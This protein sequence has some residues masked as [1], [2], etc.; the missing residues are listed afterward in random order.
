MALGSGPPAPAAQ[1]LRNAHRALTHTL[2]TVSFFLNIHELRARRPWA[3]TGHDDNLLRGMLVSGCSGL[4]AVIKHAVR[5]ALPTA[6]DRIDAAQDTFRAVAERRLRSAPDVPN[7]SLATVIPALDMRPAL[8]GEL[9]LELTD[10]SLRSREEILHAASFFGLRPAD[11]IGDAALFD[12]AFRA[13]NQI[14]LATD[15]DVMQPPGT[16]ADNPRHRVVDYTRAVL[17]CAE[18]FLVGVDAKLSEHRPKPRG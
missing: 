16:G 15:I 12:D 5:D 4:E 9:I 17:A 14:T 18:S 13:R 7:G 6:I 11:L 8:I 3:P 1:Q 10:K 2:A